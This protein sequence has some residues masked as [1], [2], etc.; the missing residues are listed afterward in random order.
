[1]DK[2]PK[3]PKVKTSKKE[4]ENAVDP[5]QTQLSLSVSKKSKTPATAQLLQVQQPAY[6][7][8]P[9]RSP[10]KGREMHKLNM[11][12]NNA[13]TNTQ[14]VPLLSTAVSGKKNSDVPVT[15]PRPGQPRSKTTEAARRAAQNVYSDDFG[16]IDDMSLFDRPTAHR[17]DCLSPRLETESDLFA[18]DV[19]DML[20]EFSLAN[21]VAPVSHAA[22]AIEDN[23][24]NESSLYN[25][26]EDMLLPLEQAL[27]EAGQSDYSKALRGTG[28]SAEPFVEVSDESAILSS[29]I[30][31][32]DQGLSS[33]MA[34]TPGAY[35]MAVL[36]SHA[37]P[38]D[39]AFDSASE[40]RPASSDSAIKA[41]VE[42]L[43]TDF[44]N[45]T[46]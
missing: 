34:K 35:E 27:S 3:P 16:D 40:E 36:E 13:K 46:A 14:P 10:P 28:K 26:D 25:M 43:G 8:A 23:Q 30:Q 15:L 41:C 20:D 19:G 32:N 31:A 5:K 2:K 42:E 18:T 37:L 39:N 11:L 6:A 44:F 33:A 38:H 9:E 45:F 29:G 17:P 22:M 21:K 12:H 4:A 1:L 24:G 7:P